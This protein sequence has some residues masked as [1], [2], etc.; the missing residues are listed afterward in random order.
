MDSIQYRKIFFLCI[1]AAIANALVSYVLNDLIKVPLYA[2]TIFTVAMCFTAGMFFGILTGAILSPLFFFIIYVYLLNLPA[3]IALVRNIF[4]ICIIAEVLLVCFFYSKMKTR[5]A[6]FFEKFRSGQ[7]ALHLF[8][9]V[10]VQLLVLVTLC[11]ITISVLGGIIE[12]VIR[13]FSAP[14]KFS[15]EDTFKLALLRYDVPILFSAILSRIPINIV[16]R[17]I[18]IF[19]G[20]GI[21][22]FLRKRL[23][24]RR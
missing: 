8:I 12:F 18:V 7:P 2:D 6:A 22:L 13:Q 21:S 19:G 10:A 5:E 17:F 24:T 15:P 16:D 14:W 20:Y 23:F 1:A 3:E 4:V 9:P 11:C